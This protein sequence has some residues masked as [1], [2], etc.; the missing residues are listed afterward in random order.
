LLQWEDQLVS[1]SIMPKV[2][3]LSLF[4][5]Y[6]EK[7]QKIE[8]QLFA[9]DID[10]SRIFQNS[11][12]QTFILMHPNSNTVPTINEFLEY[13]GERGFL[14]NYFSSCEAFSQISMAGNQPS[15]TMSAINILYYADLRWRRCS[16]V[17]NEQ[18]PALWAALDLPLIKGHAATLWFSDELHKKQRKINSRHESDCLS[19]DVALGLVDKFPPPGSSASP[20]IIAGQPFS[21]LNV[22]DQIIRVFKD[23]VNCTNLNAIKENKRLTKVQADSIIPFLSLVTTREAA[24]REEEM[25]RQ[26]AMHDADADAARRRQ[27]VRREEVQGSSN[28]Q[29]QTNDGSP[30]LRSARALREASLRDAG[31]DLQELQKSIREFEGARRDVLD[32]LHKDLSSLKICYLSTDVVAE[33]TNQDMDRGTENEATQ[34]FKNAC[35]NRINEVLHSG[36][37]EPYSTLYKLLSVLLSVVAAIVTVGIA[38]IYSKCTQGTFFVVDLKTK[39]ES[40]I[41]GLKN[42]VDN[43]NPVTIGF[44]S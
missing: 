21:E 32:L 25:Q 6:N 41:E 9:D 29:L 1:E 31:F 30:Q 13:A 43:V 22:V 10:R 3:S 24:R 8:A 2:M 26:K 37:F 40:I 38:P 28:F 11:F 4:D 39:S 34:N 14:I 15:D 27:A 18:N 33:A 20:D 12:S 5:D 42:A 19:R 35:S 16:I 17:V 23:D 7:I 36:L 44:P